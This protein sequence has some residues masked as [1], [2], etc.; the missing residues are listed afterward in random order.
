MYLLKRQFR[1]TVRSL[2]VQ[3]QLLQTAKCS[4]QRD[5]WEGKGERTDNWHRLVNFGTSPENQSVRW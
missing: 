4:W 5:D 2:P 3:Q 1:E